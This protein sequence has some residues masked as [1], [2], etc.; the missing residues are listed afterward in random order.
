MRFGY[1]NSVSIKPYCKR[2][3]ENW[4]ETFNT[5]QDNPNRTNAQTQSWQPSSGKRS[6]CYNHTHAGQ[7]QLTKADDDLR[8][9]PLYPQNG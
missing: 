2:G 8:D 4:L 3:C 7:S 9:S 6:L 1:V 5:S